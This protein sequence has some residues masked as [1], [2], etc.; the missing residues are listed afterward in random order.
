MKFSAIYYGLFILQGVLS[1]LYAQ[2]S[3]ST[4]K[5]QSVST[6]I[7]YALKN[8]PDLNIYLL[9]QD[10]ANSEFKTSKNY[11]LPEVSA[12]ASRQININ[13]PTTILPGEIFGQP[14]ETVAAQF[15]QK[16]TFNAGV[17]ATKS[18][19]DWQAKTQKKIAE[20]N[21][22]LATLQTGAFEQKLKEQVALYY[23]TAIITK[24]ALNINKSDLH[25]AD[26]IL[27]LTSQKF[28]KGL[29]DQFAVNQAEINA[30]N[31]EQNINAN[32]ILLAQSVNQLQI[33]MGLKSAEQLV[34]E[35][36]VETKLKDWKYQSELGYDKNL[37][38]YEYQFKSSELNLKLQKT[39]KLPKFNTTFY[40]GQ[41]QFRD[42][43]ALEF[44]SGSWTDYSYLF[45]SINVPVFTGFR[46]KNKIKTAQIESEIAR[47][48]LLNEQIKTEAK[49]ELLLNEYRFSVDNMQAVYENFM[50]T[51]QNKD[52]SFEQ[53]EQGIIS[54][55][56]YF[57]T[58]EDYLK[59]ESAYL[60]ALSNT[61]SYY[62]TLLSR[63]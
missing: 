62:A 29:V 43:F 49:D 50:L 59:A 6:A 45:L 23:Y 41:Q 2:D 52:L 48:N 36:E 33:I 10:K 14:G 12:S 47:T 31:I 25:V 35:E 24:K 21:K 8:N 5:L 44:D 28:E 3:L 34:F 19:L 4:V 60:N 57:K 32:K 7:D 27:L 30:N 61:Y 13:L 53:Y 26:S 63:N 40:S 15:G 38:V 56:Q 22:E 46:N 1:S 39:A 54:L 18:I 16:Y 11:M 58:F 55:D 51:S 42:D 37:S 20:V 9:Q 17:T